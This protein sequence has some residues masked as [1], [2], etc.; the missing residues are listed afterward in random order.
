MSTTPGKATYS[1]SNLETHNLSCND[2]EVMSSFKLIRPI[3]DTTL[4]Y[5]YKCCKY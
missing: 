3:K 2:D 5:E 4:A 1:T